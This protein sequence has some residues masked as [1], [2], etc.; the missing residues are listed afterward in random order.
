MWVI[1]AGRERH[2][3]ALNSA[4]HHFKRQAWFHCLSKIQNFMFYALHYAR[5]SV[6]VVIP[7]VAF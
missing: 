5:F 1:S 7:R 6:I 4:S 2:I 3:G